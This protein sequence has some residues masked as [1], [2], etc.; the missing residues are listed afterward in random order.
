M[1]SDRPTSPS[2]ARANVVVHLPEGEQEAVVEALLN[3]GFGVAEA[4]TPAD[5][6]A[7]TTVPEQFS[8]AIV[9][10]DRTPRPTLEALGRLRRHHGRLSVLFIA[11]AD[12]LDAIEEAGMGPDDEILGRPVTADSI[13]WRLEAMVV[14]FAA[15]SETGEV[16]QTVAGEALSHL[17]SRS[18]IL[19]VFNPKGGVGKTTIATNLAALLQLRKGRDVL[20]VDADTVTGHVALS[21]GLPQVRGIADVWGEELDGDGQEPILNLAT[22]HS[23]GIRVA[24]LTTNPLALPHLH[25]D[26]VAETLLQARAG[27]DVVVVD[28]HPSYGEMNLAVFATASRVLVP[29][30]PDL[31]AIRAAVQLT[32]VA[33][34]LG[35]RDRLSLVVNRA[36]SGVSVHDIER[37]T[38]LKAI[39]EIRSAGMLLVRAGNLGKT[40]VEQFPRE[41][42]TGDFDHLADKVLQLVGAE[43]PARGRGEIW[44]RG[45]STLVGVKAAAA[46]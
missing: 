33:S 36:N 21:P 22:R 46:S 2:P 29:V 38:G 28:L 13:R 1:T 14:R 37:T 25:P 24:T 5:L 19:A 20:L 17:G 18:P 27:V 15:D 9:D 39:A 16:D 23:S 4:Y 34:E 41:K 30:T 40:L 7:L 10:V 43:A 26:R 3:A 32:Q 42:V 45:V 12:G 8:H 11:S 6:V 44:S 31:P 35:V